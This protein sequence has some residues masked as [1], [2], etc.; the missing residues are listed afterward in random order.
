M[1]RLPLEGYRVIDMTEVWAGPLAN[2]LLGDLGAQVIKVESYPRVVQTRPVQAPAGAASGVGGVVGPPDAPRLWERSPLYHMANRNKLAIALNASDP[3]GLSLVYRLVAT[4]DAF[5]IGYTAGTA[6]R[7][8]LD[9]DTLVRCKP[10]LVMLSFAGWG[11]RGPYQGYATLG[12]GVDAWAGHHYLRAYPGTGAPHATSSVHSDA[13]GAVTIAFAVMAALHYRDRTGKGQLIDL[14]MGD[15]LV[16]HLARPAMDWVMNNRVDQPIGNVDPDRSPN[17]CYPCVEP[18]RWIVIVV[19]SDDEWR[20]L[21]RAMGNPTWADS[22]RFDSILGRIE[23]RA[24]IDAHLSDWTAQRT[25]YQ[26]FEQL[27]AAGVPAGPVYN[28]DGTLDDPHL[29]ARGFYRWVTHPVT[30]QYRRPGPLFTL[31]R[32]PVQFRRHTNLLGEHNYEVLSGILG[33]SE[34]E[35][36]DLIS[37]N[38]IGDAYDPSFTTDAED[39]A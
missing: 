20:E 28:A 9:Y 23:A 35:C 33:L 5:L 26:V 19:R 30:G 39:R 1:Q 13:P 8:H 25:A 24:E 32:T 31:K 4:A 16:T 10:D 11:E 36:E 14:S 22:T 21:K 15:M 12:S 29:R 7:M 6:A 2:S 27:Q 34:E 37:A 17:G 38:V 3:R 18:D